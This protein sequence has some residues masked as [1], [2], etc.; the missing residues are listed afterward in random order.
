MNSSNSTSNKIV[1]TLMGSTVKPIASIDEVDAV[2]ASADVS[3]SV[4]ASSSSHPK[5]KKPVDPRKRYRSSEGLGKSFSNT[6]T[7]EAFVNKA[8]KQQ[9]FRLLPGTTFLNFE[10]APSWFPVDTDIATKRQLGQQLYQLLAAKNKFIENFGVRFF[11]TNDQ[12]NGKFFIEQQV[13][14]SV[15]VK[16]AVVE[17]VG[18]PKPKDDVAEAKAE[19]VPDPEPKNSYKSAVLRSLASESASAKSEVAESKAEV[20][21]PKPKAKPK[22]KPKP[23][24][25]PSKSA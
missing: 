4:T 13:I 6:R 23:Q 21:S 15:E 11:I 2:V 5:P 10:S 12:A 9:K 20:V 16:S 1:D 22:P 17:T 7:A 25:G 24:S 18:E 3:A 8:Y 14:Q 19:V